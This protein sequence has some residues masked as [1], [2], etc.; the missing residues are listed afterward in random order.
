MVSLLL[1]AQ[2]FLVDTAP[3]ALPELQEEARH[4]RKP[5]QEKA[6][7]IA[8]AL[9]ATGLTA[10]ALV[11]AAVATGVA[12]LGAL[13]TTVAVIGGTIV[14]ALGLTGL[15]ASVVEIACIVVV[16]LAVAAL[17]ALLACGFILM[18][19]LVNGS[20]VTPCFTIRC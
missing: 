16:V 19:G 8:G 17:L 11:A 2:L 5:R 7:L 10:G 1:A 15:A 18:L 13:V 3:A 6:G 4:A 20:G 14:V 12:A 9:G